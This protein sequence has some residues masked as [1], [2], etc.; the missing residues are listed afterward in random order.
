MDMRS[1]TFSRNRSRAQRWRTVAVAILLFFASAIGATAESLSV[2]SETIP[3]VGA[4]ADVAVTA[5]DFP[6]PTGGQTSDPSFGVRAVTLGLAYDSEIGVATSVTA[7]GDLD[8]GCI[9]ASDVTTTG[10]VTILI[11]CGSPIVPGVIA[12]IAFSGVAEGL[13]TLAVSQCVLNEGSPACTPFDGLLTVQA[14]TATPT[15]TPVPRTP[16]ATFTATTV[17]TA[18]ETFTVSPTA[19]ETLTPTVTATPTETGTS[20][21][22]PTATP[23]STPSSTP[24]WTLTP[25][26]TATPT[27]TLTPTQTLTPSN[28][29]TPTQT[30]TP[31][32]TPTPTHTFTP[33]RTPTHTLTPTPSNTATPSPE[34]LA[35]GGAA[36][37]SSTA[38]G[39]IASRAIDGN[40]DG[41]WSSGSV[42]HTTNQVDAWWELDLGVEAEID[43]IDLFNRTDC[44]STRLSQFY[45]LVSNTP[46]AQPGQGGIFE[47]FQAGVA[48]TPTS[49]PVHANGRY[50]RIQ[51]STAGILSL[52]E[53]QVW[54]R[55]V[56]TPPVLENLSEGRPAVQSSTSLGAVA[57]RAVDGNTSGDWSD[58]SV[59]HTQGEASAWWEVDLGQT[60]EIERIDLFNRT[61]CCSQRLADYYVM[62]SDSPGV[63]PG[64]GAI[65]ERFESSQVGSPTS[66]P[67]NARG[68]YV[69]IQKSTTG[70]LSLAEVQVWGISGSPVQN[71]S[72]GRPVAQSS[73]RAG[74]VAS[75]A[76]DGNTSGL[77]T[78]ASVTHT[79]PEAGAWW[80]V[81][82]GASVAI[83]RIDIFNRTDCCSERLSQFYVLVSDSPGAQPGQAIFEHFESGPVGISTSVSVGASGRYVRIQRAGVGILSLAEVQVWSGGGSPPL[84]NYGEG[85]PTSQSSTGFGGVSPRAVDGNTSGEWSDGSV[86][87]TTVSETDAWWEVDLGETI[88][89]ERVDVFNRTDC[90]SERL[91][92]F[93]V[94]IADSPG[95]QPGQSGIFEHFEPSVAGTPTSVAAP[96]TG[97]YVRVQKAG[98][99]ILSLAEVQVWGRALSGAAAD[100]E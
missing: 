93:W 92:E 60:V 89:I 12:E 18:T 84:Q 45:V 64:Q 79:D 78:D 47:V 49:I 91:Q 71:L 36:S 52:A 33:T 38:S 16:T 55:A 27:E 72:E 75:R 57:A 42:T 97:R 10:A 90:C 63:G 30:S 24:S 20:T 58:G 23:T 99:G 65:F 67:V 50:V 76:V 74:G 40:T 66:I 83:D 8:P 80:E 13:T 68:R 21:T 15:P 88:E 2:A 86:T 6:I 69:R 34:N 1:G 100:P 95:P 82:L 4:A 81:D 54:G 96:T 35:L 46:G 94:L 51:K 19:T 59:T 62:V 44:C 98:A 48:G 9:V 73:T 43:R 14:P 87:H 31:S 25:T 53:V 7:G 11:A 3:G 5:N 70:V 22:T 37:Q 41:D 17:P 85:S 28:T 32:H 61:D 56:S 77:W 39:G 26:T 29:L